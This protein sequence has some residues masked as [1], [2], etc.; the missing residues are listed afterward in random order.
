MKEK[1]ES[2]G[3]EKERVKESRERMKES[4]GGGELCV[5]ETGLRRLQLWLE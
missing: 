2:D 4:D 3:E 5:E 1:R